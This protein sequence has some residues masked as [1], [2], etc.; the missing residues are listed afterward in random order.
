[1]KGSFPQKILFALVFFTAVCQSFGSSIFQPH[2]SELKSRKCSLQP[3]AHLFNIQKLTHGP[4]INVHSYSERGPAE[5]F[6]EDKKENEEQSLKKF[7]KCS[8]V[9]TTL[10]TLPESTICQRF[11]FNSP[12]LYIPRYTDPQV[13][14]QVF[15]I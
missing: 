13:F 15:R 10:I 5:L 6:F 12:N 4:A 8:Y 14:L 2:P 7:L 3:P 11:Q 1:M 9:V